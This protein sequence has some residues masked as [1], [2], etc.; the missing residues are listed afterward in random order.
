MFPGSWGEK[1]G[2]LDPGCLLFSSG[3]DF[4]KSDDVVHS[5]AVFSSISLVVYFQAQ[6]MVAVNFG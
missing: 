4:A 1:F 5:A 6:K 3:G 2:I